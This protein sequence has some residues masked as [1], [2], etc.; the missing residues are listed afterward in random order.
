[1]YMMSGYSMWF[2]FFFFKQKPA[3][4]MRMSDWSSDVCSSDLAGQDLAGRDARSL[5]C[6]L[7]PAVAHEMER[8]LPGRI[9]Q[10]TGLQPGG[11]MG[12]HILGD[13][14]QQQIGKAY[15]RVNGCRSVSIQGVGVLYKKKS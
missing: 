10:R 12:Q 2:F 13:A 15:C 8:H 6:E 11:Q 9:V 5:P 7:A 4:E 1:M 14:G 3:Y